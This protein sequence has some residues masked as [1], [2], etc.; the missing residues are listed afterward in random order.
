MG[1]EVYHER[2]S[3]A[4]VTFKGDDIES[5]DLRELPNPLSYIQWRIVVW[6]RPFLQMWLGKHLALEDCCNLGLQIR[7]L[8]NGVTSQ[9]PMLQTGFNL[10]YFKQCCPGSKLFIWK[11]ME[12]L[13]FFLL[14]HFFS[15]YCFS[16]VS[17]FLF[18]LVVSGVFYPIYFFLYKIIFVWFGS[19]F[20]FFLSL[21]LSPKW[22]TKNFLFFF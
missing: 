8:N 19:L 13:F 17:F 20:F 14:T 16:V 9:S 5:N 18:C 3:L 10:L 21:S 4:A 7:E 12:I 6:S 22:F 11:Y 2:S 15:L 1:S